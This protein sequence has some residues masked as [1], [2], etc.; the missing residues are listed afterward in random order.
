MLDFETCA[1]L[2]DA[3]PAFRDHRPTSGDWVFLAPDAAPRPCLIDTD[4]SM[5]VQWDDDEPGVWHR[6]PPPGAQ[7]A[8]AWCPTLADLIAL[9]LPRLCVLRRS[10]HGGPITWFVDTLDGVFAGPTPEAAVAALLLGEEVDP[11]VASV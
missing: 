7:A 6:D 9:A 8:F 2:Y 4:G 1:A 10:L 3:V 11:A 5:L